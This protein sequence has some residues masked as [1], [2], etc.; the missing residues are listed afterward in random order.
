MGSHN[1]VATQFIEHTK[2]DTIKNKLLSNGVQYIKQ[3][4]ITDLKEV[5]DLSSVVVGLFE[6]FS[7]QE[8]DLEVS[9]AGLL[10]LL[11][12]SGI[13]D[14]LNLLSSAAPFVSVLT[15]AVNKSS[16]A[17]Y[18]S[19]QSQKLIAALGPLSQEEYHDK[20]L[21]KLS[22]ALQTVEDENKLP[23]AKEQ[24]AQRSIALVEVTM[25]E[26]MK[27]VVQLVKLQFPGKLGLKKN[28]SFANKVMR[29]MKLFLFSGRNASE[30]NQISEELIALLASL[31]SQTSMPLLARFDSLYEKMISTAKKEKLQRLEM[32]LKIQK[33][34]AEK[35]ELEMRLEAQKAKAAEGKEGNQN[36]NKRF[37]WNPWPF[38]PLLGGGTSHNGRQIHT[39]PR[40]GRYYINGNGNRVYGNF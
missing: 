15:W 37:S 12:N 14:T 4:F 26:I 20:F 8:V 9:V 13:L 16:T 6:F 3:K 24:S 25:Q 19:G 28:P 17:C 2:E 23:Q 1:Q 38:P 40:G 31:H 33:Q 18:T 32:L 29:Y 36:Q 7:G 34:A 30:I 21:E 5:N 27:S 22:R 11:G 35:K 10:E 39:G